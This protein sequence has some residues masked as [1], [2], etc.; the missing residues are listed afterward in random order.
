[1]KQISRVFAIVFVGLMLCSSLTAYAGTSSRTVVKVGFPIQAGTSYIN[2]HGDYAGYLVDY[3]HQLDLFTN[4]EI[5]F[6]QVEGDLDT[7]LETLMDMLRQGEIDMLGTMNRDDALENIFLYP[8]YSYGTRYTTLAVLQ[9]DPHWIEEDFSSWDGIRVATF[10]G[11]QHQLSEFIYYATVNDFSYELVVCDSYDEMIQAVQSGQADAMIQSDISMT[12]GFRTIGRFSPSPYYFA[13]APDNTDLLQQLNTAMRNLNSSQPNLQT[14]LYD[15]HFRYMDTFQ[16]SKEHQ[17]YIRSL[18]TLK[19]LFID[20]DAPY[21]YVK[22][23]KLTG[24]AAEYVEQFAEVTGLQYEAVIVD[25]YKE[26]FPLVEQGEVDLVAFVPTNSSLSVLD[27]VSFSIP[28]FNSFSVTACTNPNPHK[29]ES[30]L[31]F[32]INTELALLEVQNS[33]DYAIRA[34]YYALS[35]YLHKEGVYDRVVVDWANTK[36]FSYAMGVTSSVPQ[37]LVTIL[38]QYASA[39]SSDDRQALLYRYSGDPVEYTLWELVLANRPILWTA[40]LIV[41]FLAG[42]FVIHLR[43]RRIAY[44]ALLA[45]NRLMHL[46]MYDEITGAYNESYFR[47]LLEE[48]CQNRS[49]IALV[50]FNI[51]G[52]KY[53]N[54]TYGT[55]RADD[56]LCYIKHILEP[57]MRDGEFFCR[58][59]ADLF[60]MVLKEQHADS[61]TLRLQDIFSK[62]TALVAATL[63]GHPLSLYSGAVF[64]AESPSPYC[65][66][67]NMSYMMVA[68]AHA[69]RVNCNTVYIFDESLYQAEQLRYYIETHMRSAL[70]KEEYQLYL[71]PKV[72]LHTGCVDGAEALVRWQPSDRDMIFPDQFIPFF[73]E[74]GFCAQLDLYMVE[75]VCKTLRFW[76]DHNISPIV[77]SVNQTKSL[78]VKEDYVEKL[79]AITKRY[80]ISPRYI[81][82]EIL[83][84]LAFE[85]I[86]TL[87]YTIQK[88]GNAGF[89][90]SMDDFGSGYSSLNTLGKLKIDELKLDRMFLLDVVKGQD[91]SQTEVLACVFSLAKKLGIKTVAEGVETKESEEIMRAMSCDYGQG[92]YY[93]KPIPAEKFREQ[94]LHESLHK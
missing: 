74:N 92:Y 26:A 83:E 7:Q 1:M 70:A 61:L 25:T 34:D 19:I 93:S 3:L 46:T 41:F 54:D 8:S 62:I 2:E 77:I 84:G 79:L 13:L 33:N 21:Q 72:N 87:N 43:S 40:L 32:R 20:G 15:L 48:C 31:E 9:D 90:V 29:H 51:R 69:K 80:H 16:I 59:S 17:D 82:L 47:K 11:Y 24:Y 23:G 60:Y 56:M 52:F 63:D 88:L 6:V 53:I 50:A 44:K 55:K 18:G 4:W 5:E 78:F 42:I 57:E 65:V 66:S 75:Q 67:T 71:Q 58:P 64:I 38:N 22:D 76:M 39:M 68:L 81:I 27:N 14:E 86:E 30:D 28:F 73:E 36:N 37:E 89:Q 91:S 10:S 85:N 49:K 12:D 94:F 45:E 35:Y